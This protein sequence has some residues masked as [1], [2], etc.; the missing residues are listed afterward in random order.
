MIKLSA[1]KWEGDD[2]ASWA[3]FRSDRPLPVVTGLTKPEVPYYKK[4]IAEAIAK[5][6]AK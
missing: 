3:I 5:E 2:R 4:Q 1:H 6:Q